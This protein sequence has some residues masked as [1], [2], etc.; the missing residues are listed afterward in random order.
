MCVC[1]CIFTHKI[2]IRN[3]LL[4]VLCCTRERGR[5]GGVRATCYYHFIS[6]GINNIT[7]MVNVLWACMCVWHAFKMS[8]TCISMV[9]IN[10]LT[11]THTTQNTID[12]NY[13]Y[14]PQ[15]NTV[16]K[17]NHARNKVRLYDI[18]P[19]PAKLQFLLENT[20]SHRW[21]IGIII[22]S[23]WGKQ[24]ETRRPPSNNQIDYSSCWNKEHISFPVFT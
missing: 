7:C 12:A 11:H 10:I 5:G 16:T 22:N 23:K 2:N 13:W 3:I 8:L 20:N 17:S 14:E 21:N 4:Y 6:S 9:S 19:T 1:V 15:D 24:C 18:H